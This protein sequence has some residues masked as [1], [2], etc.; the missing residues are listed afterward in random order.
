[1]FRDVVIR[2]P[3][4]GVALA[5]LLLAVPAAAQE[6][7]AGRVIGVH[8]GDTLTLVTA[9]H[10]Q[11]KIRLSGIDAPELGQ[12]WGTR[13]RQAL[14]ELVFGQ[15]V[16]VETSKRDRY[17]REIGKVVHTGRDI[18]LALV[19]AGMAWWYRAYSKEQSPRDRGLYERA[20]AEASSQGRGLWADREPVAPWDWRHARHHA[21][22]PR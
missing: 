22:G 16:E 12:P 2:I 13:A 7:L 14:A 1:M 8:D 21:F 3:A 9:D 6:I 17:R 4:A 15:Y 18:N 20:E 10:M 11:H 19:G 5:L